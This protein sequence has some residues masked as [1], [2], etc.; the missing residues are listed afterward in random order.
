MIVAVAV[1]HPGQAVAAV[2]VTR[3]TRA[4]GH[5]AIVQHDLRHG[6]EQEF[7]D[8]L[9]RHSSAGAMRVRTTSA[10]HPSAVAKVNAR[11]VVATRRRA[12]PM[13]SASYVSSN[14]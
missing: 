4:E 7:P 5:A 8:G 12:K 13:R 9:E 6:A 14:S 1:A 3:G 2:N 10:I 11:S